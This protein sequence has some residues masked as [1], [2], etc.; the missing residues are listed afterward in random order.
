MQR[1]NAGGQADGQADRRNLRLDARISTHS[2]SSSSHMCL[3]LDLP[4]CSQVNVVLP[5]PSAG[6]HT[7]P[8][9]RPSTLIAASRS[10]CFVATSF[11]AFQL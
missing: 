4:F 11:R 5:N 9:C 8:A 7:T 1:E 3:A 2:R 6:R 10:F